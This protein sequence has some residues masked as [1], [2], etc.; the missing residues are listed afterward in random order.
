MSEYKPLDDESFRQ[1]WMA[2]HKQGEKDRKVSLFDTNLALLSAIV[3]GI[4]WSFNDPGHAISATL[5]T[6]IFCVRIITKGASNHGT[7]QP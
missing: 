3:A 5:W 2:G 4:A 6:F 7:T 1:G